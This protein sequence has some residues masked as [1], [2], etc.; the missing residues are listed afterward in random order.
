[1]LSQQFGFLFTLTVAFTNG[2]KL[3]EGEHKLLLM[4]FRVI[5]LNYCYN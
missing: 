2:A 4:A 5:A 3:P 1:M